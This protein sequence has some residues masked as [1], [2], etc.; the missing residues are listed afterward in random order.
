MSDPLNQLRALTAQIMEQTG[1]DEVTAVKIASSRVPPLND[2]PVQAIGAGLML[3]RVLTAPPTPNEPDVIPQRR[4]CPY[5]GGGGYYKEAVPYTHPHFGKLFPCACKLAERESHLKQS[6]IEILSKL[7]SDLGGELSMCRIETFDPAWG[8]DAASVASL[9][10]ARNAA[11][12][13]LRDPR[14][15]LYFYG[16]TGVGKS[17]LSAGIAL[18]Y[19]DSGL[20]RVAYASVPALLRYIRSGYSDGSGDE[21]LSALQLIELLVLDDLGTE[22]HKTNAADDHTDS[23]LFELINERYNYARATVISSNLEL[24]AIE[25][26][27]QSRIRGKARRIQVDNKDQRGRRH[28]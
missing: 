19:A 23:L 17:H 5:C 2:S 3:E 24:D 8:C 4:E 26:R 18:A 9:T 13:F 20:G 6:R 7:Q 11:R 27:I 16:P 25:S 21:R 14:R 10:Y 28:A 22:Y 15:W 1:L 12:D